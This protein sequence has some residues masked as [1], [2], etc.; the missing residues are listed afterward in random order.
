MFKSN[1]WVCVKEGPDAGKIGIIISEGVTAT[2]KYVQEILKYKTRFVRLDNG[3]IKTFDE[4]NLKK[5]DTGKL[6]AIGS[7][8]VLKGKEEKDNIVGTVVN[9]EAGDNREI[10]GYVL[11]T[12]S[13]EIIH[14]SLDGDIEPSK[15]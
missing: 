8:L 2:G 14:C 4:S 10:V 3:Y 9:W 6:Y 1:D 7:R 12:D 15:E 13:G 11:K 5:I